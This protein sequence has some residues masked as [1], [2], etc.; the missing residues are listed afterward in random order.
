MLDLLGKKMES[1][2]KNFKLPHMANIKG[3]AHNK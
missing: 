2:L 3:N 1:N